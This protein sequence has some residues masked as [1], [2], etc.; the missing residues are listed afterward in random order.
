MD[1]ALINAALKDGIFA[2]LFVALF[3]YQLREARRM[4]DEAKAR[5]ERIQTEAREREVRI[6]DEAKNREDRLMTLAEDL[7][8]RFETLA[9]QYES[10]ALD[11]HE[12]KSVVRGKEDTR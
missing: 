12:I 9:G 1:T 5:E 7:T 3:L 8:A 10:L 11:V 2:V 4:S 6:Q